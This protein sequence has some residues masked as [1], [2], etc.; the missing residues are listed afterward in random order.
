[1]ATIGAKWTENQTVNFDDDTPA[2]TVEGKGD[3]DLDD[4]GFVAVALQFQIVFGGSADGNAEIRIR[5]SS[6]S[7][8]AVDTILLWSQEVAFEV[9]VTKRIS[10]VLR[11]VPFIEVGVYNGNGAVEDISISAIYAGQKFESI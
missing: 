7:G 4:N 8:G 10:V 1:M 3:I 5:N 6:N 2:K 11:D 9:G